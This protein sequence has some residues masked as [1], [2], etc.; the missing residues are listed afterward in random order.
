M[1][2]L[3]VT[4]GTKTGV[5]SLLDDIAAGAR[6][7]PGIWDAWPR[8]IELSRDI[9]LRHGEDG[10]A[11]LREHPV[12][13]LTRE[14]PMTNW[15]WQQ[16]R[17]YANDARL[18]DFFYGHGNVAE[19]VAAASPLGQDVLAFLRATGLGEAIRE[20]RCLLARMVDRTV[21]RVGEEAEILS[22][23]S[24][25]LREAA[26]SHH[27]MDVRRWVALDR[28]PESAGEI[29]EAFADLP[30]LVV[31][32]VSLE[33]TMLHPLEFGRFDLV[34]AATACEV[35]A[36]REARRLVEAMFA[37]LKPGGR[38]LVATLR[39]DLPEAGYMAAYMGWRPALRGEASLR[40]ILDAVPD[41]ACTRKMVF[42]GANGRI[43]YGLL[44]RAES[45]RGRQGA[46]A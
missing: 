39:P 46:P 17:G 21:E 44:E 14:C 22:L 9:L 28:D 24:Q 4:L 37:V 33:R 8:L 20:R 26:L 43:L 34:Y 11:L 25:H 40:A 23:G 13:A 41:A 29:A 6:D 30:G 1:G 10:L 31:L 45:R 7:L 15:A 5:W 18:S 32:P 42:P 3:E 16:P 27:A 12:A 19:S 2:L 38:A 36:D 35:F